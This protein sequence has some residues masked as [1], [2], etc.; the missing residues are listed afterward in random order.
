MDQG[1]SLDDLDQVFEE[2]HDVSPQ[3]YKIGLQLKL[4]PDTMDKIKGEER[5]SND[6]L[7]EMLKVWLKRVEPK[8]TWEALV[9]ALRSRSVGREQEAVT[10]ESKYCQVQAGQESFTDH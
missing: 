2:L 4:S 1:L 7:I 3:W 9:Q 5:D 6:Q 8:P 10:V